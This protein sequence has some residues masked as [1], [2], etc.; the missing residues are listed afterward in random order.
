MRS[1]GEL[2]MGV[3][4]FIPSGL[5]EQSTSCTGDLSVG[6]D[7]Q[8][9]R[10]ELCLAPA[11]HEN[12]RH[13][14]AVARIKELLRVMTNV[15]EKGRSTVQGPICAGEEVPSLPQALAEIPTE[16]GLRSPGGFRVV[17]E[18]RERPLRTEV[19]E[20]IYS[21][22]REAIVNA[23][24]HSNA[25]DIETEVQFRRTEL[26]IT[27]LDNGCGIETQRLGRGRANIGGLQAMRGWAEEMGASLYIFSK[28]ARGTAVELRVPGRRAFERS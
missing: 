25:R 1:K 12:R 26:R 14:S 5:D 13:Q 10:D 2:Q 28:A 17:V 23:Y 8:A 4:C 15:F 18:G 27:V 11:P 21:I 20:R 3:T 24:R 7:A 22:G 16:L 9:T 6:V 19:R